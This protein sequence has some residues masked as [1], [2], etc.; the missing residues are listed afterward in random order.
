MASASLGSPPQPP[1]RRVQPPP[2][3]PPRPA[4]QQQPSPSDSVFTYSPPESDQEEW[5]PYYYYPSPNQPVA[6]GRKFSEPDYA[7]TGSTSLGLKRNRVSVGGD[8]QQGATGEG[9]PFPGSATGDYP[10]PTLSPE[11]SSR[12]GQSYGSAVSPALRKTR[13]GDPSVASL[14]PSKTPSRPPL[15]ADSASPRSSEPKATSPGRDE[16][17]TYSPPP[18][19]QEEWKQ[20]GN[21]TSPSPGHT[22]GGSYTE[23][24]SS[25]TLLKQRLRYAQDTDPRQAPVMGLGEFDRS[26]PSPSINDRSQTASSQSVRTPNVGPISL[27]QKRKLSF[28]YS[29]TYSPDAFP[30]RK[31]SEDSQPANSVFQTPPRRRLSVMS[32]SKLT[33]TSIYEDSPAPPTPQKRSQLN[34]T[35]TSIESP[36]PITTRRHSYPMDRSSYMEMPPPLSPQR[37][38]HPTDT[39][40]CMEVPPPSVS[41][42]RSLHRTDTS[43]Y[44]EIPPPTMEFPPPMMEFPPP[45]MDV[46]PPITEF[47][48][49]IMEFPPPIMEFPPPI[50]EFPPPIMDFPPPIM[51]FPPP[52]MDV[53]PPIAGQRR[54]RPTGKSNY[55]HTPVPTTPRK[56]LSLINTFK[57]RFHADRPAPN[58][59]SD[60]SEADCAT[61]TTPQKSS[62]LV[63]SLKRRFKEK[64]GSAGGSLSDLSE[65][66]CANLDIYEKASTPKK[67]RTQLN[68][69]P[70]PQIPKSDF[71]RGYYAGQDSPEIY[72]SPKTPRGNTF[73]FTS[74]ELNC[75][76][77]EDPSRHAEAVRPGADRRRSYSTSA[78]QQS[79]SEAR[80]AQFKSKAMDTDYATVSQR[81]PY[82]GPATVTAGNVEVLTTDTFANFLKEQ[83]M[84][85][86]MFHGGMGNKKGDLQSWA[87][88]SNKLPPSMK[89]TFGSVDC[90]VEAH[91]CAKESISSFP[92]FKV[93]YKGRLVN[94]VKDL[95]SLSY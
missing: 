3:R 88:P 62:V 45:I 80:R 95:A 29:D 94:A 91:L 28:H 49:P 85:V 38:S 74:D 1:P 35:S 40:S 60:L 47:P 73:D 23:S 68:I 41:P 51:D 7:T 56:K 66:E 11:Y 16:S 84:A 39:S 20:Y 67:G 34:D 37:R 25:Q 8:S 54:S 36:S 22:R 75:G 27:Q 82:R 21:Y 52:I 48:P 46:P 72:S 26:A 30:S 93:Y 86:V 6:S 33:D 43:S 14:T 59:Q 50:M 64:R 55:K 65:G 10:Q 77:L 53:P 61:P 58:A 13:Q 57:K 4:G 24:P 17:F 5:Q 81:N 87:Q 15:R 70:L 71:S 18:S 44:M 78:L 76:F 83:E 19:A 69:P 92:F 63:N 42:Q 12:Q 79:S 9:C 32:P 31:D 90:A 2:P 89:Q